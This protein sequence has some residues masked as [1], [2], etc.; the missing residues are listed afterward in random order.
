MHTCFTILIQSC[1]DASCDLVCTLQEGQFTSGRSCSLADAYLPQIFIL[2]LYVSGAS[3]SPSESL[4]GITTSRKTTQPP[5]ENQHSVRIMKTEHKGFTTPK[6]E[7]KQ[8]QDHQRSEPYR[9]THHTDTEYEECLLATF[10][11]LCGT[12]ISSFSSMMQTK[13]R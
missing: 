12:S 3:C 10:L 2:S 6:K 8:S 9:T 1:G 11:C 7:N 5:T 13:T 4:I